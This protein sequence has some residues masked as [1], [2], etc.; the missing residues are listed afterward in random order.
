MARAVQIESLWNGLTDNSGN[1]LNGGKVYSYEAG[2]T[3]AKSLYQDSGKASE[4][5]N[6]VVLNAYGRANVYG[7]G[8]YKFVVKTSADVELYTLD[9]LT[10]QFS[11]DAAINGGTATGSSNAYAI[12]PSPAITA[13]ASGQEFTWIAN[14]T[15]TGSCTL[16]VNSLGVKTL[17]DSYGNALS[18]N[19]IISGQ[20]VKTYYNG[21][22]M[23]MLSQ[24]RD[25]I[26]S[27]GTAGG[28]ANALTGTVA[29]AISSYVAN[30]LYTLIASLDNSASATVALNSLS[31][32]TIK[33]ISDVN[34]AL[35]TLDANDITKNQ[36]LL[37][38]DN[39]T[40]MILLNPS[41]TG[42][43][44]WTPTFGAGGSMTFTSVVASTAKYWRQGKK[45]FF[46]LY[47][48][49]TTGGSASTD[50]SFTLPV[51]AAN[52]FFGGGCLVFNTGT[53]QSGTWN[54]ASASTSTAQVS[55][56]NAGNL[57]LGANTGFIINGWYEAA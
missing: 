1:L 54:S 16:N 8:A 53:R 39:G 36:G 44:S 51:V 12:S 2:T 20:T 57:S 27:A 24:H 31:T 18:A 56:Y 9:N 40:D 29:P 17:K 50:L 5:T 13:Y 15:N 6:P 52:A 14:F 55:L 11:D 25:N 30:S 38:L 4:A 10:Y 32:R 3:T 41:I 26:I 33:K 48:L 23:I 22:D 34:G 42:I 45:V 43:N 19:S 21:T 7:D 28:T 47:A 46:V 35:T 37:L 49:G